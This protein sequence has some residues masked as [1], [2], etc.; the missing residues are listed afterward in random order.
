[1]AIHEEIES[2]SFEESYD[3][4]EEVIRTLEAGDLGLDKSIA[5]Y[6]EG[7]RLAQYCGRKLDDAHLKVTQLLAAAADE[8]D[9]DPDQGRSEID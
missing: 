4:L 6:E 3:R 1:M 7:M 9:E 8:P 5:L 2:L